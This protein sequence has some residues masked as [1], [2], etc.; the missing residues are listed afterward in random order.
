MRYLL[1]RYASSLADERY[2]SGVNHLGSLTNPS[3]SMPI[4]CT[5]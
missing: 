1:H 4:E 2:I 3:C 5:L